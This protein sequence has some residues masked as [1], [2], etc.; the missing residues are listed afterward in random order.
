MYQYA[1]VLFHLVLERRKYEKGQLVGSFINLCLLIGQS[2]TCRA[3]RRE[4]RSGLLS[5]IIQFIIQCE[6]STVNVLVHSHSVLLH[7][8]RV[9]KVLQDHQGKW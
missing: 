8:L 1:L 5:V 9:F 6:L 4:R 3:E 2:W 7:F